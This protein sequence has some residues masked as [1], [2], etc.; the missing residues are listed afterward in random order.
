MNKEKYEK[1]VYYGYLIK[2][3]L[4]QAIDYLK[5][6]PNRKGMVKKY[7]ILM[8]DGQ[9]PKRNLR[10]KTYEI[11]GIYRDYYKKVFWLNEDV[12]KAETELG[13]SLGKLL[14]SEKNI[15][16]KDV[17]D[18]IQKTVE[19]EGFHFL[20]GTT[21]GYYGPYIW[22]TTKSKVFDVELPSGTQKYGID[23]MDHFLSRSWLDYLSFGKIG[24]GGWSSSDG[25][26][27]MVCP[28]GLKK[29][30]NLTREARYRF[31]L[32][33]KH[34]AQHA[35]DQ[36]HF[37]G[38]SSAELEYRAKLVELIYAKD[39]RTMTKILSEADGTNEAN[40]HAYASFKIKKNLSVKI[41]QQDEVG[42]IVSWKTKKGMLWR[43]ASDLLMA[44]NDLMSGKYNKK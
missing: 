32:N 30:R 31:R 17:E 38:I 37:P 26:L 4:H 40:S 33:L 3:Q 10:L 21:Q 15:G 2:G 29:L 43:H 39:F 8:K 16:L 44:D 5:R 28:K 19:G 24:T 23:M 20:G 1:S 34:E 6:F 25:K 9:T 42:D 13:E 41:F 35:Y 36:K 18:H 14:F 7:Y 11:I 22:K 27:C 12:K